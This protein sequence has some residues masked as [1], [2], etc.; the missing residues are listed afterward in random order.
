MFLELFMILE[1]RLAALFLNEQ[2]YADYFSV[3]M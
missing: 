3:D 1:E 2:E